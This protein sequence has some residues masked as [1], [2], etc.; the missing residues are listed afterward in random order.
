MCPRRSE[1]G[2]AF[3]R[4]ASAGVAAGCDAAA[5]LDVADEVV[6]LLERVMAVSSSARNDEVVFTG[7][8]IETPQP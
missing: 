7:W 6:L 8:E 5:E 3:V 4:N 1:Y 2:V